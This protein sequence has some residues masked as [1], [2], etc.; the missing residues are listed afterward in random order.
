MTPYL[1]LLTIS[2]LELSKTMH[3]CMFYP[4][5]GDMAAV[6]MIV[7]SIPLRLSPC[8]S[9]IHSSSLFSQFVK[10]ATVQEKLNN[11]LNL[12][13]VLLGEEVQSLYF[14][15]L[16]SDCKGHNS[17]AQDLMGN[18]ACSWFEVLHCVSGMI[19][20]SWVIHRE[21]VELG[22]TSGGHLAQPFAQ[23][24][25]NS[26][27]DR[28]SQG[29]VLLRFDSLQEWR[30]PSLPGQHV[31]GISSFETGICTMPFPSAWPLKHTLLFWSVRLQHGAFHLLLS[32]HI[33][34]RQ[35]TAKIWFAMYNFQKYFVGGGVGKHVYV[36]II[37]HSSENQ[38]PLPLALRGSLWLFPSGIVTKGKVEKNW[39]ISTS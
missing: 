14:L 22:G 4:L 7:L 20:N 19:K 29:L 11:L 1:A 9:V 30:F 34:E 25:A 38:T 12:L 3:S 8:S 39:C 21:Q 27:L 2:L 17:T 32:P 23:S 31:P 16:V 13:A 24:R 18:S 10:M 28:V 15:R 37:A 26:K 35:A 6:V 36:T 33:E 5:A